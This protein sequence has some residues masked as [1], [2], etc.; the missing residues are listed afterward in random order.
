MKIISFMYN[1]GCDLK[2]Y[3]KFHIAEQF[4]KTNKCLSG[5]IGRRASL[6]S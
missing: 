1:T 6:R 2:L 5:G 4:L 3:R